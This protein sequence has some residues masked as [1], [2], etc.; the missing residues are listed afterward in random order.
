MSSTGAAKRRRPYSLVEHQAMAAAVADSSL[1]QT[2]SVGHDVGTPYRQSRARAATG[3]TLPHVHARDAPV[4]GR[5][6]RRG[7]G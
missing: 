4:P 3:L 7:G 2:V 1:R 5:R 6:W